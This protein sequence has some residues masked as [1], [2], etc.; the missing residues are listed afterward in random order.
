MAKHSSRIQQLDTL[1]AN[2][3]A[4]G[5]VVERPASVVKELIENSIDAGSNRIEIDIEK[6]GMRLIRVRDDGIGIQKQDMPLALCRHATSKI[7]TQEDLNAIVS[8]GFR[9]EALASISAVSRFSL[10]S[11]TDDQDSA[12]QIRC[13][14]EERQ[15]ELAAAHPRGTT[16][17]TYDLFFNTPARRKFLR[18]EKTE[19]SHIET[20]V[21]RVALAN[22]ST[23]FILRHNQKVVL[24]FVVAEDERAKE[25]RVAKLCGQEFMRHALFVDL[26]ATGL[27]V[28]G[29]IAQPNFS[30]S[31]ADLQYFYV[32]GRIVR[33][34]MIN[35]ALKRA[36][37]DVLPHKRFAA[38]VLFLEVSANEVDVNAHPQK[39]EVRFHQ[40]RLVYDF[41][42]RGIEQALAEA[43]PATMTQ[44][45]VLPQA[46]TTGGAIATPSSPPAPFSEQS[47]R[48][49]PAV[50]TKS[51]PTLREF[52][53]RQPFPSSLVSS[54]KPS[55]EAVQQTL[56]SY[57][58]LHSPSSHK[59]HQS[60]AD[61]PQA[62][63]P[64]PPLG[65]ALA[66]LKG[67][68]ILAENEAG[69]IIV[70]MHAAHE[71]IN[72]ERMKQSYD[73]AS[74]TRQALLLPVTICLS[75]RE[76][77]AVEE[78]L[79]L[80]RSLGLII[81]CLSEETI[82]LRELPALLSDGDAEQLVRDVL[83]D[84]L[85]HDQS[86][87]IEQRAHHLLATMSCHGSVR[88]NRQLS[89]DEMNS[90]LRDM[91]QTDR[92]GQCNHGRPTWKQFSL[93]ELDRLFSRGQ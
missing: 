91:E 68:Y 34:K 8:L 71:R 57:Q 18:T 5:E 44:H 27:R 3:I 79:A 9:G 16:V 77:V 22:F 43:R 83:A 64:L 85:T 54:K 73:C 38:F 42:A 13:E 56:Q 46:T 84:L 60:S 1:L 52:D 21:K 63:A 35:H 82:V 62:V 4:A 70:D 15:A 25:Q 30:R 69:L 41:I 86:D 92:S 37:R 24:N 81:E 61:S 75:Q 17:E 29:W 45:T 23:Q 19:F 39:L 36:Y 72:Y 51:S 47:S 10:T 7:R 55:A 76:M 90:I 88:A 78:N 59:S 28:H 33:D 50:P 32:N 53:R 11:A 31:Q 6:G 74:L 2:Q 12:F 67:V 20:L 58:S 66:Q 89:V 14:G 40:G 80:L 87:A 48:P 65:F 49:F 93:A 26:S